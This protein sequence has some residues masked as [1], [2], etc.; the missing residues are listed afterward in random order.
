ML[1]LIPSVAE[2]DLFPLAGVNSLCSPCHSTPGTLTCSL[3]QDSQ[4]TGNMVPSTSLVGMV[5]ETASLAEIC[6]VVY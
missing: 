4:V 2:S 6:S 3:G 1:Q 5:G